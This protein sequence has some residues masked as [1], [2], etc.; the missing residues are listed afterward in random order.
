MPDVRRALDVD[1]APPGVVRT[2]RQRLYGRHA[3]KVR[4]SPK[5]EVSGILDVSPLEQLFSLPGQRALREEGRANGRAVVA[6]VPRACVLLA[7]DALAS[8]PAGCL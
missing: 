5:T 6:S 8:S 7:P 2:T 3:A 1:A 4:A